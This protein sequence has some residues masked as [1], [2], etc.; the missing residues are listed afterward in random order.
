MRTPS[1]RGSGEAPVHTARSAVRFAFPS[2]TS[3]TAASD[4]GTIASTVA[5]DSASSVQ[6]DRTT[7]GSRA[8]N[9]LGRISVAPLDSD[10]EPARDRAA[11]MKHRQAGAEAIVLRPAS[12]RRHHQ[13]TRG[14]IARGELGE[15]GFS[16][17]SRR[18]KQHRCSIGT[19]SERCLGWRS[20]ENGGPRVRAARSSGRNLNDCLESG[21]G[22]PPPDAGGHGRRARN[23]DPA[24]T[25]RASARAPVERASRAL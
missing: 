21:K 18:M 25:L 22:P 20:I 17:L 1:S 13:R 15:L 24:R 10:S 19:P 5:C 7:S 9:R 12:G 8:P 23:S 4:V 14:N 11:D 3:T 2:G 6:M 16:E